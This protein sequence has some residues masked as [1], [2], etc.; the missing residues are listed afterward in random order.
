MIKQE[1][2]KEVD[3]MTF[4]PRSLTATGSKILNMQIFWILW[5]ESLKHSEHEITIQVLINLF[6]E[7]FA[8]INE[9]NLLKTFYLENIK[10]IDQSIMKKYLKSRG[11]T[12]MENSPL[13]NDIYF[14]LLDS[15]AQFLLGKKQSSLKSNIGSSEKKK[16]LN[17]TE[18]YSA[19]QDVAITI[20][21]N[22][23]REFNNNQISQNEN[24][25]YSTST[26]KSKFAYCN[27]K[28]IF[29]II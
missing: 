20:P 29:I 6:N 14:E 5:I 23:R 10:Q 13:T 16:K 3:I 9:E 15:F 11:M 24:F 8:N 27:F 22:L 18:N 21:S 19:C 7:A 4:L 25:V 28:I 12:V 1:F 17:N 2:Q 26:S